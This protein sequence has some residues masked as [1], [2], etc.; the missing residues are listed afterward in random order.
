[1]R[2]N[3]RLLD[4]TH[5]IGPFRNTIWTSNWGEVTQAHSPRRV[6]KSSSRADHVAVVVTHLLLVKRPIMS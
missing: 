3:R 2:G 5:E 6:L 1:M 4:L